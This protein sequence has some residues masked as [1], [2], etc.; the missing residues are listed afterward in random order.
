M[1][2]GRLWFSVLVSLCVLTISFN[3]NAQT[4]DPAAARRSAQHA[5]NAVVAEA[6]A[7]RTESLAGRSLDPLY[8]AEA[9][10]KLSGRSSAELG[11]IA[12][13]EGLGADLYGQSG[14]DLV[15]VPVPPCR[16]FDTRPT[17]LA[18]G[19]TVNF[20]FTGSCGI[21]FGAA[22]GVAL[23]FIAVNGTGSG[24]V[25][26]G[27]FGAAIPFASVINYQ[28]GI[29][30]IANGID[31]RICDPNAI[32]CPNDISVAVGGASVQL[33]AD[34]YGYFQRL[35]PAGRA[36]AVVTDVTGVPSLD[37]SR[38]RNFTAVS[39][40]ATGEYCLTLGSVTPPINPA[41]TPVYVTVEWSNSFGDSLAAFHR[42][43][44]L[45]CGA[46][47]IDVLTFDF[48]GVASNNVAFEV[49]IP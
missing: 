27:P 20:K 11:D 3:A 18:V 29:V 37:A 47:Q 9:V 17:F 38:T 15:F 5:A 35:P 36:V 10:R 32:A 25:Q 40:P 48:D 44:G 31:M 6:I 13:G 43:T 21:P 23:N 26:V 33:V 19:P 39:R 16:V 34:V 41:T 24:F 4:N 2:K 42:S 14:T 49:F 1:M 8:R 46:N 22:V 45:G 30:A 7:A 12:A 28:S